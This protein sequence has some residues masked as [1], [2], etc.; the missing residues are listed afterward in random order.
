MNTVLLRAAML[1]LL[2]FLLKKLH[3]YLEEHDAVGAG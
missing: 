2:N 1:R 3:D